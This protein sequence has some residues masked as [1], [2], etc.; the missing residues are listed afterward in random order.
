MPIVSNERVN[1]DLIR[2]CSQ[3]HDR[4]WPRLCDNYLATFE[5]GIAL[6]KTVE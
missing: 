2:F 6:H 3:A 1:Q 4:F 5:N